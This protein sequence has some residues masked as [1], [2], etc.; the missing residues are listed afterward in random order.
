MA[1]SYSAHR[2]E[3]KFVRS[4][5][6]I[7]LFLAK[8]RWLPRLLMHAKC[9]VREDEEG[10]LKLSPNRIAFLKPYVKWL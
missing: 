1:E 6:E 2:P 5:S 10:T 9:V 7:K 4:E 3:I 8:Y